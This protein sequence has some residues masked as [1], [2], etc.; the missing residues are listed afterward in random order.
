MNLNPRETV[1][2]SKFAK[3]LMRE[4]IYVYSMPDRG[5][6]ERGESGR[7]KPVKNGSEKIEH[8]RSEPERSGCERSEHDISETERSELA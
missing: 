2:Y 4:N 3:I 8:E 5:T 7:R 6:P 1:L